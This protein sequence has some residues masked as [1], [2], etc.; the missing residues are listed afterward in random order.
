[1]HTRAKHKDWEKNRE[2]RVAGCTCLFSAAAPHPYLSME[3]C[4]TRRFCLLRHRAKHKDWEKNREER[5]GTWRDFMGKKSKDK[6]TVGELKAPKVS[7]GGA[8]ARERTV[9]LDGGRFHRQE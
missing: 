6:K 7:T 4:E 1:M 2:E 8:W 9:T 5:V 3:H